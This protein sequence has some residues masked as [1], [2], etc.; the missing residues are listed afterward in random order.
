MAAWNKSEFL[1][2]RRNTTGNGVDL[3]VRVFH[4]G[5]ILTTLFRDEMNIDKQ[6]NSA[7]VVVYRTALTFCSWE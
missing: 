6:G 4:T 7:K 5:I 1:P 2:I 3:R